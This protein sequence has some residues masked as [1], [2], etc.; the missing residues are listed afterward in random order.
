M[1][2]SRFLARFFFPRART[3]S[4]E[5]DCV[6]Q[7]LQTSDDNVW[8]GQVEMPVTGCL[9]HYRIDGYLLFPDPLNAFYHVEDGVY[10]S[11]WHPERGSL[12]CFPEEVHSLEFTTKVSHRLSLLRHA[13]PRFGPGNAQI[14]VTALMYQ[15]PREDNHLA[16]VWRSPSGRLFSH[17]SVI[18][19]HATSA[20]TR[21]SYEMVPEFGQ[22]SV[23]LCLN[24]RWWGDVFCQI[25]PAG[26]PPGIPYISPKCK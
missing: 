9:Y 15:L 26:Y 1:R 4:L 14:T 13:E 20:F 12:D 2:S 25:I 10:Y 24:G 21:M 16:W 22:W 18:P 3:V 23:G 19:S 17:E 7:E 5:A 11:V 8:I 6:A